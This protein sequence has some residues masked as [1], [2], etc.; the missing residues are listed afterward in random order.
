[1]GKKDPFTRFPNFIYDYILKEEF[2]ATQLKIIFAVI[3]NTY[4]WDEEF[5]KLSVSKLVT[6][7][8]CSRSQVI[9]DTK[10]LIADNV[11]I[12]DYQGQ[13]RLLKFNEDVIK[14]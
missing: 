12:E 1:M 13:D 5:C 9:R 10:K 2:T 14:G 3:R 8:K 11:L 7:T 4:G 6:I